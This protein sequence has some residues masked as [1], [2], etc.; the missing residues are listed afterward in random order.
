VSERFVLDPPEVALVGRTEI[1]LTA[2]D[3]AV[4]IGPEGPQFSE[5]TAEHMMADGEWGSIPVDET[6]PNRTVEV[7]LVALSTDR[8]TLNEARGRIQ[9]WVALVQ[10]EGGWFMREFE[11]GSRLF[12]DAVRAT[13]RWGA[14]TAAAY[15]FADVDGVLVIEYLPDPYGPECVVGSGSGSGG[16]TVTCRDVP[17]D[18]PARCRIVIEERSGQDQRGLIY[19]VRPH[20]PD[21][22][23]AMDF[24]ATD[25]TPLGGA[26]ARTG[27]VEYA[28]LPPTW[29][30][31]LSTRIGGV[32]EM[33]HVGAHRVLALAAASGSASG[34]AYTRLEWAAGGDVGPGQNKIRTLSS[35]P[36]WVDLGEVRVPDAPEGQ[37]RWEGRFLVSAPAGWTYRIYRV[38]VLPV[39]HAYGL[40]NAT[41]SLATGARVAAWDTFAHPAGTLDGQTAPEGGRWS[42]AGATGAFLTSG[43]AAYRATTRDSGYR[44]AIL[45]DA[46]GT[47][48]DAQASIA[49]DLPSAGAIFAGIVARY[50][51]TNNYVAGVVSVFE[52]SPGVRNTAFRIDKVVGGVASPLAASFNSGAFTGWHA[53]RLAVDASGNVSFYVDGVL[54]AQAL[55]DASLAGAGALGAGAAGLLDVNTGGAATRYYDNFFVDR[56]TWVQDAVVYASGDATLST[57]GYHRSGPDGLHG[58]LVVAP[59]LPRLPPGGDLDVYCRTSRAPF[60]GELLSADERD[61]LA[62]TVNA[63]PCHQFVATS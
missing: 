5:A 49:V 40:V 55:G 34:T 37:Q 33:T 4:R 1:D 18:Y 10:R 14:S 21:A 51:D 44:F 46:T 8:S 31:T 47:P 27:Y 11:D 36:A 48:T 23:A 57:A 32:G 25:L 16:V 38:L 26:T 15:G 29:V 19:A 2:P 7:P 35:R 52:T 56:S 41:T 45:A 50:R 24:A 13:L 28:S 63:R 42:G 58:E 39:D 9:Q 62:V 22:T 43:S 59:D 17:G 53:Y 20:N 12:H 61:A 60:G 6:F 3:G 54:R 30:A